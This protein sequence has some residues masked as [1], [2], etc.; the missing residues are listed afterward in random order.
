MG[1][2]PGSINPNF[3]QNQ[4]Y[5]F[6][7]FG[8]PD[9]RIRAMALEHARDSIAIAKHLGKPRHLVLV[10]GRFQLSRHREHPPAQEMV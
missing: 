2:G 5:K 7:S 10:R 9:P 1:C 4:E 3:F 8:N 6:G